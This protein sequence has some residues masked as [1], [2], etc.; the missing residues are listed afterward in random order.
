MI[1]LTRATRERIEILFPHTQDAVVE[2]LQCACADN[3][4]LYRPATPEGLERIRF[5]VLKLSAG[6][7]DRL[8]RAIHEAQID[9]RDV[10]VAAGFAESV[11]AH[12]GWMPRAQ[13]R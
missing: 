1:E 9:W 6:N 3:L 12:A 8:R 10:L 5:A 11:M 2:L 4:P 13:S 7:A